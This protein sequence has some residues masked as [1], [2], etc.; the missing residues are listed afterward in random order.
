MK[1]P[2]DFV[3]RA[4]R[5]VKPAALALTGVDKQLV[6]VG[7]VDESDPNAAAEDAANWQSTP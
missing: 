4:L 1:A 3:E 6:Y 2:A 7:V 5:R